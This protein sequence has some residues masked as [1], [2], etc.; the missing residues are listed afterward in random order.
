MKKNSNNNFKSQDNQKGLSDPIIFTE[1]LN[2]IYFIDFK[3]LTYHSLSHELISIIEQ[4]NIINN[5][6]TELSNILNDFNNNKT[7]NYKEFKNVLFEKLQINI[8]SLC[9]CLKDWLTNNV[10]YLHKNQLSFMKSINGNI[11]NEN[12]FYL[13]IDELCI[14]KYQKDNDISLN[15]YSQKEI[16][17]NDNNIIQSLISKNNKI[18]IYS[19]S[20]STLVLF[21]KY[22]TKNVFT[23]LLNTYLFCFKDLINNSKEQKISQEIIKYFKDEKEKNNLYNESPYIINKD[24]YF[25]STN[26]FSYNYIY[27][28]IIN[29]NIETY[30][31]LVKYFNE[32]NPKIVLVFARFLTRE[33]NFVKQRYFISDKDII[34][35]PHYGGLDKYCNGK[36]DIVLAK[37]YELKDYEEYKHIFHFFENNYE[38]INDAHNFKY[39]INKNLQNKF[40]KSFCFFINNNNMHVNEHKYKLSIIN[41]ITL[42][43]K[44]FKDENNV[45]NILQKNKIKF[46]IILKYTSDNPN[47]KHEVSIILNKSHLGNFIN[48]YINK[49]IDEKYNTTVLIQ[50]I[51]KHGGYVLKIY[52]IGNKNYIDYRSSLI[53]ID[54]TNKKLVDE[55]FKGNGY[56]NFKTIM[57]ESEEY[58]KN[59]WSKYVEK[60][61]I[62]NKVKNNKELFSYIINVAN[63]FE[64][65]SHM[66]LFGIDVLIGN[67]D[68]SNENNKILY[69]IDANSLPGYKKG[70]EVE[71]DL[72]NYLKN[73]ISE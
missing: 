65:Y 8:D 18:F 11:Y 38:M 69:I 73:I 33:Q 16:L 47:F 64:I 4:K 29:K 49:I 72:R 70:F 17:S 67:D 28:E 13:L 31:S 61:G 43:I 23:F 52:H 22:Y 39:F 24:I 36:I 2:Q 10:K 35:K 53:D 1:G 5:F 66:G 59:I 19:Y 56:W 71:K 34:Y 14:M 26:I 55:L 40:L 12:P 51:S 58:K 3:Y 6:S 46:P 54:E 30:E 62:E 21:K 57:L 44:E 48:N 7:I 9:E 41:G 60:N 50:H 63:L 20:P 68:D 25:L 15:F 42:D 37:S 32:I 45:N 27:Y